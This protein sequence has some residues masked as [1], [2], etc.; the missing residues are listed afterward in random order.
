MRTA[1][2]YPRSVRNWLRERLSHTSGTTQIGK[3]LFDE[4]GS[5]LVT[6]ILKKA[7][8]KGVKI[9]LPTD[10]VTGNKLS[11]DATVGAADLKSGIDAGLMG[12]DA[13]PKSR[14]AFAA[15]IA[16]AKTVVWN[17]PLGV[18]EVPA[19]AEGT[20]AGL[21]AMAAA[22]RTGC[23]T[24][25]GG[26]DT[27]TA[28]E[29]F[30]FAAQMSHVSTGGGASLELLEGKVLPGVTALS[31]KAGAASAASPKSKL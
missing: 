26:G 8:A 20:K 12:L 14:A 16:R 19:F 23:V 7:E 1:C 6:G 31:A 11:A 9:H 18:F 5:K 13:G 25:I 10:F 21:A 27:A 22:T 15:V 29:Q 17:G 2:R 24:I 4:A 3:S 28:C 30:G